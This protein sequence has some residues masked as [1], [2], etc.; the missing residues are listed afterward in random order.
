[1]AVQAIKKEQNY[2]ARMKMLIEAKAW[3]DA[4]EDLYKN[5][6]K[7]Q[8]EFDQNLQIIRDKGGQ[9]IQAYID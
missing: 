4:I 7:P 9:V 6:K 3:H 1:M 8:Q 2:Q 5:G